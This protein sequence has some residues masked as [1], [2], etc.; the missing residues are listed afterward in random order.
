MYK[1]LLWFLKIGAVVNLYFLLQTLKFPMAS[2]D[3]YILVP[4]QVLFFV[5]A[6]RCLFPVSYT[7]NIVLHDSF[8]SSIFLTRLLA[9]FV[10]VAYIYQFSYVLRIIN[11][12]QIPIIDLLSWLMVFQVVISQFFVWGAILLQTEK[13]YFYEE[14][15]WAIIFILNTVTSIVLYLCLDNLGKYEI[16]LQINIIFGSLYLPW[17]L[18]HLRKIRARIKNQDLISGH[19]L[20]LTWKLLLEGLRKSLRVKNKTDDSEAWGGTVGMIWMISY[21]ASIIPVWIYFIV[22]TFSM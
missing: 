9:T 21:W 8:F 12:G 22:Y 3:P 16:L 1:H 20:N 13:Y 7:K 17:Q 10:E 2:I 15:G 18:I 14:F 6:Y 4:A 19:K 11:E 5:S